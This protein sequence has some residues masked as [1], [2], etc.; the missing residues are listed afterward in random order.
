MNIH[1]YVGCVLEKVNSPLCLFSVQQ[2]P[3]H[4]VCNLIVFFQWNVSL[5]CM[6]A[7]MSADGNLIYTSWFK[8]CWPA[9]WKVSALF[10][11]DGSFNVTAERSPAVSAMGQDTIKHLQA[12]D[13]FYPLLFLFAS[14]CLCSTYCCLVPSALLVWPKSNMQ[15][16]ASG[17]NA[18][19][20]ILFKWLI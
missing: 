2:P 15:R 9:Q 7:I 13:Y 19:C 11:M 18:A 5:A 12:E 14:Q 17:Y 20:K 10:L 4:Y 3:A 6:L 8:K 16:T 1:F